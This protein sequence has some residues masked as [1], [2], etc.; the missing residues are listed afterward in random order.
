MSDFKKEF[1]ELYK[2]YGNKLKEHHKKSFENFTNSM[3][4]FITHLKFMRDY[5]ILTEPLVL[6]NGEENMKIAS[7]ATAISA[8][9]KYQLCIN[10]CKTIES[11]TEQ[12]EALINKYT[13]EKEFHWNN[14]WNLIRMNMEAWT[15]NA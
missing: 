9:D 1:K 4:Y 11:N 12:N 3:D 8:Y 15:I 10:L 14:F 2:T 6:E 7:L 5:F 13:Q